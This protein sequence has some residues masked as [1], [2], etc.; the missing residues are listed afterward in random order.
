MRESGN[1]DV[2]R[3]TT[4]AER[5]VN[6]G[7]LDAAAGTVRVAL[8]T[9]RCSCRQFH[10]GTQRNPIPENE[11][12]TMPQILIEISEEP[13]ASFNPGPSDTESMVRLGEEV[14]GGR[15]FVGEPNAVAGL[16][17]TLIAIY[18]HLGIAKNLRVRAAR[19]VAGIAINNPSVCEQVI[20]NAK[21]YAEQAH[22]CDFDQYSPNSF[23]VL[24]EIGQV[25][26]RATDFLHSVAENDWGIPKHEANS[27]LAASDRGLIVLAVTA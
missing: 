3:L 12:N 1:D 19:V 21:R 2:D 25:D 7:G 27:A 8:G 16:A 9:S 10:Q 24:G 23:F 4:I 18:D 20:E 11:E 13:L 14:L 17:A 15:L 5:V 6:T 26:K 22:I